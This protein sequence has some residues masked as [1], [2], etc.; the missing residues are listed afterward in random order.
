[1][2][3]WIKLEDI[4]YGDA[5]VKL[6]PLLTDAPGPLG[7]QIAPL[8]GLSEA[9]IRSALARIPEEEKG[10]MLAGLATQ[11]KDILLSTVNR[12][13]SSRK[14]GVTLT[15]LAVEPDLTVM[16]RLGQLDYPYLVNRFLPAIRKKL[17][18]MGGPAVLLRPV[19]EKASAE[20]IC[21]LL[22]RLAGNNK[23]A[24]L[25]SLINQ[26]GGKLISALEKTAKKEQLTIRIQSVR[27]EA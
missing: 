12:K 1:M 15:D 9:E 26:N 3:L 7:S 18:N 13:L 5:A 11:C 27:A 19:I 23:D 21:G 14:V 8:A 25:V 20:Q 24:F 16:A 17:L 6:L 10:Q 2:K 22:D 4:D